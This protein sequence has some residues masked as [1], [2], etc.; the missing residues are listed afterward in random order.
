MTWELE[1]GDDQ[2]LGSGV[3]RRDEVWN[4]CEE[5]SMQRFA[6]PRP[7]P[8]MPYTPCWQCI[9]AL[10]PSLPTLQRIRLLRPLLPPP[11]PPPPRPLL[12]PPSKHTLLA[13]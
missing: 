6:C 13:L 8:I 11:A 10:Q 5:G 12:P 1:R 2:I 9:Q 4:R 7:P 3:M